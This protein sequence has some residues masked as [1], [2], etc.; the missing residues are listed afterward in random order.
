MKKILLLIFLFLNLNNLA[1]G[2]DANRLQIGGI[3]FGDSLL[4]YV[5]EE[6]IKSQQVDYFTDD[7]YATSRF[8]SPTD[9]FVH[10]EIS[11]KTDDKDYKIV[12]LSGFAYLEDSCENKINTIS[13]PYADELFNIK[14]KEGKTKHPYDKT[15]ESIMSGKTFY[16]ENAIVAEFQCIDWSKK[17]EAEG[18]PDHFIF[19]IHKSKF[20]KWKERNLKNK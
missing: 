14:N 2:N 12:E 9:L 15:G 10:L 5:D 1:S 6:F 8:S 20:A 18:Y 4:N 13:A 3:Y 17:V 16:F 7:K 19:T 11:Y